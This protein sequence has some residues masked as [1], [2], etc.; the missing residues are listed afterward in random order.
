MR[1][2]PRARKSANSRPSRTLSD[3]AIFRRIVL[4]DFVLIPSSFAM[5]CPD[6]G[7]FVMTG[8]ETFLVFFR[9]E[10]PGKGAPQQYRRFLP[11]SLQTIRLEK[12]PVAPG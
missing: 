7:P 3:D 6:I 5:A 10:I 4:L 12:L 2:T 8:D 9:P 1:A 11:A